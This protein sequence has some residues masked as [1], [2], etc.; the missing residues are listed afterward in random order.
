MLH[1]S[2]FL[3]A[4]NRLFASTE[5]FYLQGAINTL[6]GLFNILGL[7][8]NIRNKFEVLCCPCFTVGTQ[9][10]ASYKR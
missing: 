7:R 10:E 6:T 3:Y 9:P 1:R 8:K 5:P 2:T 4:D